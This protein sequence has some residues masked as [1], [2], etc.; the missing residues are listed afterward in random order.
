[1]LEWGRFIIPDDFAE[2]DKTALVGMYVGGH[3]LVLMRCPF[4]PAVDIFSVVEITPN[5]FDSLANSASRTTSGV[6]DSIWQRVHSPLPPRST[7]LAKRPFP[8][9]E[10][11][12]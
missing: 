6:A 8:T 12:K 7:S 5:S 3:G 2:A 10:S 11:T 4:D 9:D 1:M